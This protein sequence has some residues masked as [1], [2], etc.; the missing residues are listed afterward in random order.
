[1]FDLT[2]LVII[3][4]SMIGFNRSSPAIGIILGIIVLSV[5]NYF[6]LIEWETTMFGAVALVA[7]LA[8]T[9]TRR[10]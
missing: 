3:I 2:S 6:T 9:I 7:M 1:M 5:A 4:G 10:R 8:V